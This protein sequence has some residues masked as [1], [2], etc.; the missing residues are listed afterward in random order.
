MLS[1]LLAHKHKFLV[2]FGIVLCTGCLPRSIGGAKV[3]CVHNTL[4]FDHPEK[5]VLQYPFRLPH[6]AVWSP[7]L[8]N[9]EDYVEKVLAF[10][11]APSLLKGISIYGALSRG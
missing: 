7:T 3:A 2:N 8:A 9:S 10:I 1:G 5:S 6:A 11:N 4:M